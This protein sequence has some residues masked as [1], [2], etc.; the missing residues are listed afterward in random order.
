MVILGIDPGFG[1]TG[2]GLIE[3]N[4]GRER[5]PKLIEAGIIRSK[6][7]KPLEQRLH[8]IHRQLKDL[9]QEFSPQLMVVEDIYSLQA[10]P[11]SAILIGHVRGIVLLLAAQQAIPVFS[12]FPL[13]VKKALLGNG[14]A[15]KSQ[16][17]RMVQ[18][19]LHLKE[20]LAPDDCS[21]ALAIAL[22]HA[23]RLS[24]ENFGMRI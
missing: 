9:V 22:C 20:S 14:K 4:G 2:Y 18:T 6:K 12:Y 10:F 7:T 3:V 19:A 23:N 1:I 5:N 11:R 21:D 16:I 24:R 13:Q 15:T 8:E 17:Q